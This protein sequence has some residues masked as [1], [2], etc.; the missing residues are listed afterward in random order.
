MYPRLCGGVD[1]GLVLKEGEIVESRF[2]LPVG[3]LVSVA[4]MKRGDGEWTFHVVIPYLSKYGEAFLM[5][6]CLIS[7][8]LD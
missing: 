1:I 7:F 6:A 8:T 4:V 2:G 5:F 3:A